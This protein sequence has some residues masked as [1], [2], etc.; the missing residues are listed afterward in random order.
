MQVGDRIQVRAYK[1]DGTC[2]RWWYATVESVETDRIV[3]IN[4]VG[5]RV[6]D[7]SGAW[8]S[9]CAIRAF[10]WLNRWYS[11]IKMYAPTGGLEEIHV[12]ISSPVEVADKQMRFTDYELDISRKPPLKARIV[13]G[14]DFWR[15]CQG[16]PTRRSSR[17]PVTMW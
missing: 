12:N 6:D 3:V 15:Q 7:I 16:M 5:H 13:D 1:S 14:D 11:L 2:Y 4:P 8:A 17:E 10:Y 9:E